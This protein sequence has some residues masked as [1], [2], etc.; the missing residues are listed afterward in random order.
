MRK[1]IRPDSVVFQEADLPLE[2]A[3]LLI[4]GMSLLITGV[5][6]FPIS[7]GTF[8]YYENGLFGLLLVMFALQMVTLGKTPFGD[9]RRS[10]LLV[11]VGVL[12]AAIGIVTCFIPTFT[13]IPRVLLLLCF[14]PGGF[15]LLLQ[16]CIAPDKLRTWARYG[17]VFHH[18]IVGCSLAYLF[19]MLAAA[20]LWGRGLLSTPMTGAVVLIYGLAVVYLA[21]VLRKIYAMYPAAQKGSEGDVGLSINQSIILL[22]GVFMVLL[23]ALLIPVGLGLLPFSGSAQLGLLMVLFAVQMLATGNT[24]IGPFPRTWLV[25][26]FGLL[27]AAL[28]IVSCIIPAILVSLLTILV[29]VLNI[30]GG[31]IGLAKVVQARLQ[32]PEGP[33]GSVPPELIRLFVAQLILNLLAILFGSA[34]LIPHLIPGLVIGVILAANG[35]VLLYLLYILT[36]LDAMQR[37]MEGAV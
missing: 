19:S 21:V 22:T 7:V 29:G 12:I 36:V 18:L 11:A 15:L 34:M 1:S 32:Q 20:L 24:P 26:G 23:G 17:G 4:A 30:L 13:Q 16:M 8:P 5:L 27:F 3:I 37:R 33:H 14:G 35:C 2:V 10:T 28:G 6:L 9:M 31:A 25:V